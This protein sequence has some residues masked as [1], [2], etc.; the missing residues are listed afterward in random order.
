MTNIIHATD[1]LN[2][3]SNIDIYNTTLL[4]QFQY[5]LPKN[6]NELN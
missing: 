3:V 2:F 6:Y 5:I 1:V 4:N